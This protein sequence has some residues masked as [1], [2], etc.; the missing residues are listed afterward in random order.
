[1]LILNKEAVIGGIIAPPT[2][3]IMIKEEASLDPSPKPLQDKAK[4]V[5][6]MID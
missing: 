2:I 4:M 6:N 3:D 1:V 5:G